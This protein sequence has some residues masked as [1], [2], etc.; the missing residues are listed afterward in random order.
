MIFCFKRSLVWYKSL[1]WFDY[2]LILIVKYYFLQEERIME[3]YAP[4]GDN[5]PVKSAS[6]DARSHEGENPTLQLQALFFDARTDIWQRCYV[7]FCG[8]KMR[9]CASAGFAASTGSIRARFRC[10]A[11]GLRQ[12]RFLAAI[13]E[14][15]PRS[16]STTDYGS[17]TLQRQKF[18]Y[19]SVS[20]R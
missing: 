15:Q 10:G 8:G 13:R 20:V 17:K 7:S 9:F 18:V 4:S 2:S 1:D 16:P 11:S 14:L 12:S 3:F 5:P 6:S 19:F